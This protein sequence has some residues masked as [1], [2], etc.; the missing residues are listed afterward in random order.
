MS[1]REKSAWITLLTVLPCF[2]LYFA[3]LVS[4]QVRGWQTM[5]LLLICVVGLVVLQVV[6]H[7]LAAATAPKDARAPKDE[8]E[9][10]IQ[11][12][13]QS[14]GYYVL[15][16]LTVGLLVP[17]H[18]GHSALDMFNFGLLNV[19]IATLVVAAAQIVMYRR[20]G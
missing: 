12:R 18:L 17:I 5:W 19:V 14:L 16:V 11:W 2:A 20:G 10:Q 6:L 7:V 13:S 9:R 3:T 1:F 8:R 15:T 4:G